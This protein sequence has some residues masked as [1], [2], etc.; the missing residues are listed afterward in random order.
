[1][2][3]DTRDHP[4]EPEPEPRDNRA[5]L[6]TVLEWLFPWPAVI[7][8]LWIGGIVVTG[9]AGMVFAVS[10]LL[11]FFWRLSKAY[12]DWGLSDHHQ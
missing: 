4:P 12:P 2:L 7:V 8:W 5:W 10:A 9:F 11:V 1:M 6:P 3:I